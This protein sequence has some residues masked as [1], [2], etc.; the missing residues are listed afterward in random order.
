MIVVVVII[1]PCITS[2]RYVVN[3][4]CYAAANTS[5]YWF[6][7]FDFW[8]FQICWDLLFSWL[9][10]STQRLCLV[11]V[12]VVKSSL[13]HSDWIRSFGPEIAVNLLWIVAV[14]G[15]VRVDSIFTVLVVR[16][17]P[18]SQESWSDVGQPMHLFLLQFGFVLVRGHAE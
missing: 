11:V 3:V 10:L 15:L 17:T 8:F 13:F 6:T 9:G 7:T 14:N 18:Y 1:L 4:S 5:S 16:F 2:V 12:L